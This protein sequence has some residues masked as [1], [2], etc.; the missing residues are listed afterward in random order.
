MTFDLGWPRIPKLRTWKFKALHFTG[1]FPASWATQIYRNV[2]TRELGNFIG[3]RLERWYYR[4]FAV[5]HF[6]VISKPGRIVPGFSL[7]SYI[8]FYFNGEEDIGYQPFPPC[9]NVSGQTECQGPEASCYR[10]R[11]LK[12]FFRPFFEI[13]VACLF[14][15]ANLFSFG[16]LFGFVRICSD[17]F[18]FVPFVFGF[19]HFKIIYCTLQLSEYLT[20]VKLHIHRNI[21]RAKIY[22]YWP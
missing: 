9:Y 15:C 17:L 13:W 1:S 4:S 20:K 5:A 16:G 3:R 18:G 19:L 8:C 2:W 11:R 6:G 22:N 14:V 21:L 7:G 12:N 10:N